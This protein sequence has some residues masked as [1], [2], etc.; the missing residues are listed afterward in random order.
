V[1][2]M[3]VGGGPR[4][5]SNCRSITVSI[6]K[7]YDASSELAFAVVPIVLIVFAF[8][9]GDEAGMNERR[10]ESARVEGIFS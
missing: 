5:G 2:V 7:E 1:I 6:Q 8:L 10:K 9:H 4:S 3:K